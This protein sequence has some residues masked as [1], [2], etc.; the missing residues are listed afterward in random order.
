MKNFASLLLLLGLFVALSVQTN[1]RCSRAIQLPVPSSST[2]CSLLDL[3]LSLLD[4]INL[5]LSLLGANSNTCGAWY[6]IDN[7]SIDA[8]IELNACPV[9]SNIA[10]NVFIYEG[11]CNNLNLIHSQDNCCGLD[12]NID[13]RVGRRYYVLLLADVEIDCLLDL[14]I[15]I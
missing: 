8:L 7:V 15:V 9:N 11:S 13:V 14:Q 12:V 6:V 5:R 10:L 1:N 2:S 4:I 3:N